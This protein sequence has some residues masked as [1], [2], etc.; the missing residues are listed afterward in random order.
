[1]KKLLL[2]LLLVTGVFNGKAQVANQAVDLIL[3]DIDNDGFEIFDLTIND[4]IIL[5]GQNPVEFNITYY[6]TLVDANA[7]VNVILN[8][9]NYVNTANPESIFARLER[10]SN[11]NFD[12]TDFALIV[13]PTPLDLGPFQM[14]LCDDELNGSTSTDGISTFNLTNLDSQITGGDPELIV[15][16]Y[17]SLADLLNDIPIVDSTAY[18]NLNNPQTL[19]ARIQNDSSGCYTD[20]TVDLEVLPNPEANMPAPLEACDDNGDGFASFYPSDKNIEILAGQSNAVV[21]YFATSQDAFTGDPSTV[22]SEPYTNIV[23]SIQ[24]IYARVTYEV[25]PFAIPC[26]DVTPLDLVVLDGCPDIAEPPADIFVNEGD[27]NGWARFDLTVNE[28]LMLG[29]QDPTVFLFSYHTSLAN[30]TQ[31]VNAISNPSSYRNIANPQ[32]IYVRFYNSTSNGYVVAAFQIETDG[33]LGIE[34]NFANN[35]SVYPNPTSGIVVIQ[36]NNAFPNLEIALFDMNGRL[37]YSELNVASSNRLQLDIS[38][39]ASGMYLLRINSE[40]RTT[41]KQLVKR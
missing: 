38:N 11:G 31:D 26:F 35:F 7:G 2:V 20:I 33:V 41:V 17:Q 10:I 39:L 16:Y 25:P 37:L 9:A 21:Q 4:P 19:Y 40:E 14:L 36:S 13:Q 34:Q 6:L 30:A 5:G 18:Q 3:C 23:V 12:T 32:L 24:T 27:D 8:P 15:N 1:M 28:S 22:L 29:A